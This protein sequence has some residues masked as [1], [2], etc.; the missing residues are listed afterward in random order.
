[1]LGRTNSGAAMLDRSD[2]ALQRQKMAVKQNVSAKLKE[3]QKHRIE[4]VMLTPELAMKLLERNT[5]NRPLNQQHVQ[6]ISRQIADGKWRFNG[7]TIKLAKGGE[8]HQDD[9]G[10]SRLAVEGDVLDGQHRCWAV[11]D[12]TTAVETIIVYGIERD[13]FSTIDTL[14]KPRNGADVLALNGATRYRSHMSQTLMWLIRWQRGI[15]T[16][17]KAPQHRIENSDIEEAYAA[18]PAIIHAVERAMGLR[19]LATASVIAFLFYVFGNRNPELAERM[20]TTLEDPAGIG[21]ND[22][23]FRLRAYFTADSYRRKDALMT[24]ALAIKAANAAHENKKIQALSW[25]MQGKSPEPFP[26]LDI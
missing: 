15:L 10:V 25:R 12:S 14:R 5:W 6:R 4:I 19:G 24:I 3:A 23:F 20:M 11:I 1:M 18:H 13:A 26:T 8:L 7:D 21:I 17:Y 2:R 22:P 9:N 16:E